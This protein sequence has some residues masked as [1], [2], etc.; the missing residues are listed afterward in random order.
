MMTLVLHMLVLRSL[1][2][3]QVETLSGKLA[4]GADAK[5]REPG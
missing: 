2:D 1:R 5:R 3:I 4:T